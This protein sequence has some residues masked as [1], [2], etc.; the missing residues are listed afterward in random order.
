MMWSDRLF[1]PT[2]ADQKMPAEQAQQWRQHMLKT[3]Q[4]HIRFV[5]DKKSQAE[6]EQALK[7]CPFSL[8]TKETALARFFCSLTRRSM[9]KQ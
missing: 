1:R 2:A 3:M 4:A 5:Q 9:G 8:L 6:L 7:D